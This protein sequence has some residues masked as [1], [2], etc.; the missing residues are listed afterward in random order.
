[1]ISGKP[2]N[3]KNADSGRRRIRHLTGM[4]SWALRQ[5]NEQHDNCGRDDRRGQRAA[6]GQAAVGNGLIDEAPTVAPRGRVR[7]KATQNKVTRDTVVQ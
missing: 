1:M 2:E 3:T 7:M 4:A 5:N 6:Q